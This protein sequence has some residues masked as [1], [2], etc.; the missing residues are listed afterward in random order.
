MACFNPRPHQGAGATGAGLG[1]KYGHAF[2]SSPAPRRG[3]YAGS[4]MSRPWPL[5][6]NPRPHQGA[7]ATIFAVANGYEILVSILARTKARALLALFLACNTSRMF[8]SSP[9]PRRGR[10]KTSR[11]KVPPQ[12]KFQ[13][14]PAPRRG[15]YKMEPN[16]MDTIYLFQSSPA[17]RRG[18][19]VCFYLPSR[20]CNGFNPR[21]HQG[22]GATFIYLNMHRKIRVSILAR[23]KARALHLVG[24]LAGSIIYVSILARTKARAL[25]FA[26]NVMS[27]N[28]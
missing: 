28:V 10:Y 1:I 3:R 17:P 9:A 13:S 8:Q 6:F 23:T 20:L 16:L 27:N 21:P 7:G 25:Q 15:R 22:A 11:R 19:Y 5:C 2:Q 26:S 12:I 4:H 14:S 18:R 24:F